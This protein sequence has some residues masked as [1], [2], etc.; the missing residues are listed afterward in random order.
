MT[1][2]GSAVNKVVRAVAWLTAG[3]GLGVVC[4][5]IRQ[6]L[7]GYISAW[8]IIWEVLILTSYVIFIWQLPVWIDDIWGEDNDDR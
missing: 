3:L 5:D 4:H 2:M 8:Q 1:I 6:Y 7:D